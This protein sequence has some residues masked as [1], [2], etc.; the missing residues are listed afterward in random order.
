MLDQFEALKWIRA[1]IADFGGDPER[2]TVMGQSAGSAATHDI[3][4]SPLTK[5]MIKGAIVESGV[6]YPH[7]PL[8]SSL[9]ENHHTLEFALNQAVKYL[10][11]KNASTIAAARQLSYETFVENS[12]FSFGNT[13]S[14]WV[15]TATL[16]YYAMPDTYYNTLLKGDANDVPVL[17]GITRDESGAT[18][19]LNI[20]VQE[21][22]AD[23]N[24]TYSGQ[25]VDEFL[26]LYP[27]ANSSQ[28]SLSENLQ[29]TERSMVGTWLWARMWRPN[30]SSPVFTYLWDH[31]PP[32][33]DQ[34]AYH[35]SEINDVL[36]N[37][38][39][40]DSPWTG[41]DYR[42]A[43]TM[44]TY[45]INTYWINFIKSGNPNGAALVHWPEVTIRRSRSS[46]V[47]CGARCLSQVKRK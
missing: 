29:F 14:S 36:N 13:S 47:T 40:P 37:L 8:C 17:T 26:A 2:I 20:T 44:N 9:D 41:E 5:G 42:I 11:S 10:A 24:E 3:L 32:G 30:A 6:R 39:G 46:L 23:L 33:K 21:Y 4:N 31:A 7:D 18:Y 19:G 27:A 12:Q 35:E 22:L 38:Y 34:G 1:N 25:L 16:D 28:A 15:F 43:A 45:W